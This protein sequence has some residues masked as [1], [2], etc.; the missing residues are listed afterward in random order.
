MRILVIGK[1]A[2][3]DAFV[4]ALRLSGHTVFAAPGNPGMEA[5]G[6]RCFYDV[7]EMDFESIHRLARSY[8]IHIVL[9]GPE[10]P[11]QAGIV[12]YFRSANPLIPIVGPT[13]LA[14]ELETSKVWAKWFM[15]RQGIPTAPFM[16]FD[17]AN[18]AKQYVRSQTVPQVVKADGLAAG[19]GVI[20][21][22]TLDEA[23]D[24]VDRIMVRKEFGDAGNKIVV[25][26]RLVGDESSHISHCDGINAVPYPMARDW[27]RRFNGD[28]GPNTGSMGG[29]CPV[30]DDP[31]LNRKIMDEI[32]QPTIRGMAAEGRPFTGFLY[33]GLMLTMEGPKVVEF[34][35]RFGDPE[36][37]VMLPQVFDDFGSTLQ[38]STKPNGL[39]GMELRRKRGYSVCVVM[40]SGPYP[41]PYQTGFNITGI[42]EA[43]KSCLVLHAG[44]ALKNGRLVTAGGRVNDV[45]GQA[46]SLLEAI[47]TAYGGV[48]KI[49]F[50]D[51]GYR[52]DIGKA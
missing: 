44:T 52:S 27:K 6:A 1:G 42:E 12:D 17:D 46:P 29:V 34:N 18:T 20:V 39:A 47:E 15:T 23:L 14:A 7:S 13:K 48:S 35:V 28:V 49:S 8:E 32:V 37:C 33:V 36:A 10:A 21:T 31:A 30:Y 24:A 41:G 16:T 26:N 45:V 3:E 19:K 40:C 5:R 51:A 9:V 22:S 25:E 11:L 2:R 38:A 50:T 4:W 43:E